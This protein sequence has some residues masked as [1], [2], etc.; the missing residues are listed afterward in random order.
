[1]NLQKFTNSRFGVGLGLFLGRMMPTSLGYQL[2]GL[3]AGRLAGNQSSPMVQ[4]V[5]ANQW[6]VRGEKS[7]PEELDNAVR[8]V[9]QHAG[10]CFVDLYHNLQNRDGLLKLV[11]DNPAAQ[12]LIQISQAEKQGV[13][14]AAPHLSNFDMVLLSLAYRGLHGQ[15]LTYGQPTG[16]YKIQNDI[17][18]TTG[19]DITPVS[20]TTHQKAIELMRNGGL[21]AT[22]VDRPIRRKA[23][24]LRFFGHPSPLPAG[25]IRM[26]LEADV[27]V[28][29]GA[30][31]LR[32]DGR[33]E[34]LLSDLIPM[35][36]HDDPAEEIRINGEAVLKVIEGFI[37]QAPEQW[38][39]YYPAWPDIIANGE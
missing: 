14:L 11:V 17:R 30:A 27:P 24:T 26:A 22:A 31:H 39:M 16:G 18:A 28:V 36:R 10:R 6:V 25:H 38:L 7:S 29:V 21:V 4:A 3:V 35:Q 9:F 19:L 20:D 23:H 34:L 1:M 32:T 8:A 37:R 13:F 5:R 15:V 2:S 12:R 33:Y